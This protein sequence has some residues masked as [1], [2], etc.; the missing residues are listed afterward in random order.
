MNKNDKVISVIGVFILLVASIGIYTWTPESQ[1][2]EIAST[3]MFFESTSTLKN[4]PNAITVSDANPFYPLIAT[5]LAIHYNENNDQVI[6]PLYVENISSPSGAISRAEIQIDIEAD[7]FLDCSKSAE[8]WSLYLADTYWEESDTVLFIQNNESGYHLGVLATPLAS[9]LNIPIIVCNEITPEIRKILNN[10]GVKKSIICGDDIEGFGSVMKFSDVEE[11][12]NATIDLLIEKFGKIEYLTIT[13]PIDAWPPEVLDSKEYTFEKTMTT[14]ALTELVKT[15]TATDTILGTFKIPDD[16]KYALVKFKGINLNTEN[17]DELG[18]NVM[19]MCGI[20]DED[21]PQGL[22]DFEILAGGTSA[23]GIPTRDDKGNVIEDICYTEAV[24]YDR[25]GAEYKIT[26]MPNWLATDTGLVRAEVTVEKLSDPL[27]PMMKSLSSLAPY[28]TAYH[29]GLLFGK[30][31]FAFA[32][33]DTVLHM[34]NRLP[35]FYMPRRNPRLTG[36]SNEHVLQIHEEINELLLQLANINIEREYDLKFLQSYYKDNPLYITLVGGATVLPQYTYENSIEVL[37]PLDEVSYYFGGG[38]PS[39]FIYGNIDPKPGDWSGQAP[40]VYTDYPYQENI[41]GRITGWDIQDVSALIAR[42]I[43]YDNIIESLDEWK[44]NGLVQMGGGNDFQ[45]PFVRYKLFGELLGLIKRG[46]PMK[47]ETGASYFNG[48]ALQE[49][50]ESLGFT[51][52][53]NRENAATYQGYS[54][55]AITML[56]KANLL[57]LFLMSPRQIKKEVGEA[58]VQGKELQ[59]NSNFI[60]ANAHGNQHMFGMGDVGMYKLGLGLPNGILPRLLKAIA[61]LFGFGPGLS[62][63]DHGYYSTRN[64]ENMELGPSFLWIESCICGKIDGVYPKQGISQAY[65][66]SG[67]NAV[68]AATTCSNVPGGYLDPKN[69]KYDFPGQTFLRYLNAK[70][71]AKNGNYPE[72]H[73]GFKIYT[74]LCEELKEDDVGIG[75][76]YRNARNIYLPEDADWEVWWS[77]PLITT[78]IKE[79]DAKIFNELSDGEPVGLDP[80]LDNKYMSFFEYTLYGDPA[81]NPYVPVDS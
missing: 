3:D 1:T 28:L 23:G 4:M 68:I 35:G 48:L 33:D 67:C 73:F 10:L 15:A 71:D 76:A 72:Q 37:E 32:A 70:Q 22:Q 9:Y 51:T 39:D 21:E 58:N 62:L 30:P 79:L 26:C 24:L 44:D 66:H 77:P 56:K 78:G 65:L 61:T 34:G 52:E 81:F 53:Y 60:L 43:F 49:T 54:N 16:Y 41:I 19:F 45:K 64:V 57:N 17:V 47:L 80:R 20:I 74:D 8:E 75:L 2:K 6:T 29:K 36:P 46:E 40:D 7:E 12:V 69:T 38:V 59:E 25:G 42:T 11:I 55:E 13:N 5:P 63:S 31:E 50:I 18:D 27:Y 14:M